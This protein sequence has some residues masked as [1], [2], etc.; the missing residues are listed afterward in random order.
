MTHTGP[1][2]PESMSSVQ[3]TLGE[4]PGTSSSQVIPDLH[5]LCTLATVNGSLEGD[6]HSGIKDAKGEKQKL[7]RR[8][9]QQL[10]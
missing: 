9:L 5:Q 6:P 2:N 10:S 8:P 1:A 4:P 3:S 7:Q